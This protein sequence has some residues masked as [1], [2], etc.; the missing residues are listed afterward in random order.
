MRHMRRKSSGGWWGTPVPA[1]RGVL[2]ALVAMALIVPTVDATVYSPPWSDSYGSHW[3]DLDTTAASANSRTYLSSMGYHAYSTPNTTVSVAMADG[4]SDAVWV[5]F[6]HGAADGATGGWITW[7]SGSPCTTS[8]LRANSAVGSCSG[9]SKCLKPTYQTLIHKIKLMVFAGCNTGTNGAGASG[10]AQQSNLVTTAFS[11]NGVDSA[12]GF[13][14]EV[15]FS[16]STGE[17]WSSNFFYS[18]GYPH[19]VS[20]SASLAAQAVANLN[21]GN[22]WGWNHYFIKGGSVVVKPAAYGS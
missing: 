14:T 5:D 6:G 2:I 18:L 19:T 7:C 3:P 11:Y 21:G 22:A 4:Q 9:T 8:V 16:A 15:G 10:D 1:W 13:T 12:I 20:Q 17:A